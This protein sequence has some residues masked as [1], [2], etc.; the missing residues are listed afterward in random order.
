MSS[1]RTQR[2]S[3]N[4]RVLNEYVSNRLSDAMRYLRH[5]LGAVVESPTTEQHDRL[6]A[7]FV[8]RVTGP[9]YEETAL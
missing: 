5:E 9:I 1:Q 7:L 3:K 6:A 2:N 8:Q 4:N